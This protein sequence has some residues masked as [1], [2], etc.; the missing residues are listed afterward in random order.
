MWTDFLSKVSP[1]WKS[2]VGSGV[3][4][5]WPAGLGAKGNEGVSGLVKQTPYSLGYV[6]LVYALQNKMAYGRIRNAK[7]VFVKA[8]LKSVTAAAAA[9]AA[10]MPNDF[11]VS[12]T[13]AD[14]KDAYPVCSFTWLLIPQKINDATKRG[15]LVDFLHWMLTK[16]QTMAEPLGYAPLPKAVTAK[17]EAAI[18]TIH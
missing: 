5:R 17:E 3:A 13:N 6:E 18:P 15:M 10:N 11:R 4:V 14:G 1:A 12:I 16:G 8:E 2:R 7:G 9:A